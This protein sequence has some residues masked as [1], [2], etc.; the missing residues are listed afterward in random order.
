M[1]NKQNNTNPTAGAPNSAAVQNAGNPPAPQP[2]SGRRSLVNP[3]VLLRQIAQ[4]LEESRAREVLK[5]YALARLYPSGVLPPW[6]V[7]MCR[8]WLRADLDEDN[9]QFRLLN[10]VQIDDDDQGWSLN[11]VYQGGFWA[12]VEFTSGPLAPNVADEVYTDMLVDYMLLASELKHAAK[13][14]TALDLP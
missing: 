11:G 9:P 1:K 13:R 12:L 10:L 5:S 6:G 3:D 7:T 4:R 8:E 2:E 14:R